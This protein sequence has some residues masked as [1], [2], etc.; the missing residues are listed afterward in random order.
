MPSR[1]TSR[2]VPLILAAGCS[3]PDDGL[4]ALDPW[5]RPSPEV[6]STAAFFFTID[7]AGDQTERLVGATTDAC[8]VTEI[9]RSA[10]TDGVMTMQQLAEG[11]EIP[12]SDSVVLEPG[13]LHLMCID[14]QVDFAQG[15]EIELALEFADGKRMTIT[16]AVE[17]R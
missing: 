12:A 14:K 8:R 9:H 1:R 13:G 7:N 3:S 11:L 6:A 5:A 4:T 16:A 2:T 17:D 15:T 10:M